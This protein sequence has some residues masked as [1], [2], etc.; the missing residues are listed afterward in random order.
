M[1]RCLCCLHNFLI[2]EK[3]EKEIRESLASDRYS[4][5]TRGGINFTATNI[6][7]VLLSDSDRLENMLHGGEHL[8][9]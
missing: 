4:I 5:M 9:M 1:V 7:G 8:M 6:D 3:E 2:N